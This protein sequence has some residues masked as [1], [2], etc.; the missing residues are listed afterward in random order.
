MAKKIVGVDF[1]PNFINTA[2]VTQGRDSSLEFLKSTAVSSGLDDRGRI[3]NREKIAEALKEIWATNG[4][5]TK[6]V[7][8][9]LASSQVFVRTV[10]VPKQD[11]KQ[12]TNDLPAHIAGILPIDPQSL[13]LDFYP[14]EEVVTD[15]RP[16]IRGL[17]LAAQKGAV[18]SLV[19]SAEMA[20]LTVESIDLTA[21]SL[22]RYYTTD[23]AKNGAVLHVFA[24][25]S[26]L[27]LIITRDG[28]P[29]LVRSVPI[30][31][32]APAVI[33]ATPAQA[34][35]TPESGDTKKSAKGSKAK[36]QLFVDNSAVVTRE[37]LDTIRYYQ[38]SG[39]DRA[40]QSIL[41]AGISLNRDE[42]SQKLQQETGITVFPLYRAGFE[43]VSEHSFDGIESISDLDDLAACIALGME[44]KS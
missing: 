39:T 44:A 30:A 10:N 38:Q 27:H 22:L 15:G 4:Y 29:E 12:L 26:L 5:K 9:G 6:R 18:E 36:Q 2:L 31:G 13:I 16:E 17:V 23:L 24:S 32:F 40:V 21:F 11:L 41:L 20:G 43:D 8:L 3:V 7:A 28:M 37:V 42:Y 35:A 14:I 25:R 1:E 34:D 19:S 33:D